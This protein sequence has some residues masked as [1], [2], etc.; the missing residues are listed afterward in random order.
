MEVL[1]S[2][3]M[4]A[5]EARPVEAAGL[6]LLGLAQRVQQATHLRQAQRDPLASTSTFFS[7]ARA[8]ARITT[9]AA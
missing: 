1:R 7:C 9:S 2:P 8:C 3:L 6:V 4:L 5:P